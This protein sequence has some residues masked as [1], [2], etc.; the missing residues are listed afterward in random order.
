[1]EELRHDMDIKLLDLI[2][3]YFNRIICF[4]FFFN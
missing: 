2:G 1:M 4:F 3:L